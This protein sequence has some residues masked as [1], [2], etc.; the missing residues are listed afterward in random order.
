MIRVFPDYDALSRAAAEYIV[1]AGKAAV[2]KHGRF[3]IALSGGKT[4]ELTYQTIAARYL[5]ELRLWEDTHVFWTDERCVPRD[6]PQSNYRLART[7][8]LDQVPIP[9]GQVHPMFEEGRDPQEMADYY[10]AEFPLAA[11]LLL[12]GV[13][14]DGH[15]ASIFPNSPAITE[16]KRRIL[17]VEAP[18]EPRRR[19][20]I[21]P[22]VIA[23]AMEVLVLVSGP[24]K[25]PALPQV[26]SETGSPDQVPARL[27]RRALWFV[28]RPAA[29][30][31]HK[32]M[33]AAGA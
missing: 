11:D 22:R 3:D 18:V 8:F 27:V 6:S 9:P 12:L 26:F 14:P 16:T 32:N 25:A 21:T 23:N 28:D 24:D 2:A 33:I 29:E 1:T 19:L 17:V 7:A 13:G 15:T 10:E 20:T 4:P 5:H 30:R 31:I